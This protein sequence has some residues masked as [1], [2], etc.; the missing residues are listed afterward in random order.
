[1]LRPVLLAC[2]HGTDNPTGQRVVS[3]VLDQVEFSS[4][5]LR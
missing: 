2:S 5:T 3:S 1:M 4:L